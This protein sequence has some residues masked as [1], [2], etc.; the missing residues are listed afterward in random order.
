MPRRFICPKDHEWETSLDT[1]DVSGTRL[2]CP[3]CGATDFTCLQ[4]DAGTAFAPSLPGRGWSLPRVPGYDVVAELGQGGMGVVYKAIDRRRGQAVALKTLQ[5]FS[6]SALLRFKKEFRTLAEVTHPNLV[7][8]YEPISDGTHWYFTMELV[9]GVDFLRHVRGGAISSARTLSDRL[10]LGAMRNDEGIADNSGRN[11]SLSAEQVSRLRAALRQLAEGIEALHTA[12][13]LHRDI[14]PGNVLVTPQ[15]RVVLL[16]FG[17]A[18]DLGTLGRHESSRPHLAG[19]VPYMS[20]EQVA[21][22]PLSRASDWYSVGVMLFEALTGRRPFEGDLQTMMQTKRERDAPSPTSLV[23][24]LPT[25]L[26]TL[27]EQLLRRD[28]ESRP[29][30]RDILQRLSGTKDTL[31]A[32][33]MTE[34]PFLGRDRELAALREAFEDVR[35][36]RTRTV[37]VH[38]PSG[39]GKSA[40]VRHFL[41]S[42]AAQEDV[43]VLVGR[44]YER[45][46]V[47]YKALDSLV[48]ALSG[49]LRRLTDAEVQALLPRD[50]S[51][52]ARVFPVLERVKAVAEAPRRAVD[53]PDAHE[54]RHRAFAALRELL[55]RLGDRRRLILFIDDLQ[56]GD[57]DSGL[58]LAD[59][60]R[61]PDAP[62]LLLIASYRRED[63]DT[64]PCVRALLQSPDLAAD[65][66]ELAVDALDEV[67][68]RELARALLGPAA[69]A[70]LVE[71]IAHESGG[72]PLFVQELAHPMRAVS[73]SELRAGGRISLDEMLWTRIERLPADERRLLEIVAIAGRPLAQTLARQAAELEADERP[74]V[75]HLRSV[76]LLRG[77]GSV[78]S[79]EIETYHDRIRETV[80]A[81]L[82]PEMLTAHHG[83]LARVLEASGPFDA[84]LLA[85]HLH[86]AGDRL[87]AGDCYARAAEQASQALAFDW[88]ARLYR[89][90]LELRTLHGE[91][92]RALRVHLAE[93][94]AHAG[95]GPEAAREYLHAAEGAGPDEAL[96]L[97]RRAALHLLTCGH[98]REG[99]DTLRPLLDAAGLRVPSSPSRA[100]LSLLLLR[101]RL[102]L[103]GARFMLRRPQ[104]ID[105]NDIRY[106][107]LCRSVGVGLFPMDIL[108]AWC[109]LT[110]GLLRALDAGDGPRIARGLALEA[111]FLVSGGGQRRARRAAQALEAADRLA[112]AGDDP[113]AAGLVLLT[114]GMAAFS[115]GRW[116]EACALYDQSEAIFREHG[117]GAAFEINLARLYSLLAL[118]YRG[119]IGEISRRGAL[120]Y[121]E[122]RERDDFLT[123][124]LAGLVKLY[125]PLAEDDPDGVRRGLAEIVEHCPEEGVD[126]LRHNVRVWQLNLDLYC[127]DGAAAL[128]RLGE[129]LAPMERVLV[130]RSRHLSIPWQYKRGCCFLAAAESSRARSSLLK[131]ALRC[132]RRLRS[133]ELPWADGLADLLRAGAAACSGD[134]ESA[135]AIL[136]QVLATFD[137]AGMLLH[138]AVA[139]RRLGECL[140]G[141]DGRAMIEQA[142]A[143]MRDHGI[144]NPL[145]LAALNAPGFAAS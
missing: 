89:R 11:Y 25:D 42:A 55:A 70:E 56:W 15:G 43:V 114:R 76:R 48:D 28:P 29:S 117:I 85:F 63:R 96:E 133:E 32:A 110:R 103:R 46:S 50:A 45:E 142:D 131:S 31:P 120:L 86:Q 134:R 5:G 105:P 130:S 26:A 79:V 125:G 90:S 18:A 98:Y 68:A 126:L 10:L 138:A 108:V 109:F 59:L 119:E 66:R 39:M 27:T 51:L 102:R 121:Q 34:T 93:S 1:S 128:K 118:Y 69:P 145:R 52:L 127:G 100:L 80:T 37:L 2:A 62:A 54:L 83:R 8:L 111:S 87:R 9:E 137:A 58:L 41:A 47:P 122:A 77:T 144:R 136:R 112:R 65:R 13:K 23:A 6:P 115:A 91:E 64:S 33:P 94:L 78:E 14:K 24:D 123:V 16:D 61:P 53:L 141:A 73:G 57:T 60:V 3:V 49:Y 81:H 30:G 74:L 36:G 104:E 84:E 7:T 92:E 132:A 116:A 67:E 95:R 20:P 135:A 129:P 44:C 75:A 143:V 106:I 38:S 101:L 82:T 140:A 124:M 22:Q 88:A 139:R 72:N 21:C 17:L 19:T 107:D 12:G 113:S 99:L 71:S 4:D 97:R 35:R 40:L